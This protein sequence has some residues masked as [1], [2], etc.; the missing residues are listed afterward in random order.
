[1]SNLQELVHFLTWLHEH[2]ADLL[3]EFGMEKW[4]QLAAPI[5]KEKS[6]NRDGR[7]KKGK[8]DGGGLR[9]F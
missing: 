5:H 8:C 3:T 9:I 7:M 6:R 2:H 1:L 4:E